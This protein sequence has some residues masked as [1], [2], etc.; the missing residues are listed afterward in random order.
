MVGNGSKKVY[1][2]S[3]ILNI[4]SLPIRGGFFL[5]TIWYIILYCVFAQPYKIS[6]KI[7]LISKVSNTKSFVA[8]YINSTYILTNKHYKESLN[9][10]HLLL[11]FGFKFLFG[12]IW[13]TKQ[14]QME[15]GR[16]Q[17]MIGCW[18]NAMVFKV[19]W[20]FS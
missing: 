13:F 19:Q 15:E 20:Y 18:F 11:M 2:Y 4:F 14:W 8:L 17:M 1:Y 5:F 6:Y 12:I 16:D 9:S 7:I 3:Y 10:I